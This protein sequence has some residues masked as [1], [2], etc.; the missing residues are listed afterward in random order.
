MTTVVAQTSRNGRKASTAQQADGRIAQSRHDFGTIV[1]MNGAAIF[2][3]GHI[4][5]VMQAVFNG[6]ITNDKFCMSRMKQMQ[7]KPARAKG[8]DAIKYP[9]EGNETERFPQA[10]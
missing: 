4:F 8:K 2:S 1:Y 9:S 3:H 5:D 7:W 6:T 10:G